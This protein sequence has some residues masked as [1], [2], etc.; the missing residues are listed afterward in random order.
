MRLDFNSKFATR[1]LQKSWLGL[2][3]SVIQSGRDTAYPPD[4]Q[5][6]LFWPE[7]LELCTAKAETVR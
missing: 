6:T 7:P 2:S 1:N 5:V 3:P 4:D